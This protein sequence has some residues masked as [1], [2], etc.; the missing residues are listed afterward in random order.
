MRAEER[1]ERYADLVVRIGIA[2]GPGRPVLILAALE[3]APVVRALAR[4]AYARAPRASTS[5]YADNHVRRAM[6]EL[7]PEEALT[8]TPSWRCSS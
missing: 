3:H 2:A 1:L 8:D 6:I 7:G 5:N 4:A